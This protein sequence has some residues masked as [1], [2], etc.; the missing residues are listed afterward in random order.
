M[1]RE[2]NPVVYLDITAGGGIKLLTGKISQPQLLGRMHFELRRDLV[3]IACSNFL[4]L[5]TGVR[6]IGDDGVPYRYKGTKIFR[7]TSDLTFV[8]GDLLDEK[9]ECSKSAHNGGYFHDENFILRHVGPGCLSMSNLGPDTNGSIFQVT[10]RELREMDERYVV[11]G[12][13]VTDESFEVL[14]KINSYGTEWGEPR[15]ELTISDCGV[16]YPFS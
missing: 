1:S 3:P 2:E 10:F 7:V 16:A 8:G 6:G 15:E 11:I 5:I 13:L 12:C 9:G 4:A 14:H